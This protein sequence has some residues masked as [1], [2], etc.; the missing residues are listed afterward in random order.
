[1]T[2]PMVTVETFVSFFYGDTGLWDFFCS[3]QGVELIG[4]GSAVSGNSPCIFCL[5]R[6][7]RPS[8]FG[9]MTNPQGSFN[10]PQTVSLKFFSIS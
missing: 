1:M 4:E 10:L 8:N 5:Q 3:I 6:L 2:F 9:F 7:S